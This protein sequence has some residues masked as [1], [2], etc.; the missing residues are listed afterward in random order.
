MTHL[1]SCLWFKNDAYNIQP[2]NKGVE[3]TVWYLG[4]ESRHVI[5]YAPVLKI[6]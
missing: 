2:R 3:T 5:F 1:N 4:T 6:F